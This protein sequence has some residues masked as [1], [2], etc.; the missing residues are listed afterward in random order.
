MT[1]ITLERVKSFSISTRFFLKI[2]RGKFNNSYILT[3]ETNVSRSVLTL[4]IKIECDLI[5]PQCAQQ[6]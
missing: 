2:Y 5:S 4:V 3:T 1:S 6:R